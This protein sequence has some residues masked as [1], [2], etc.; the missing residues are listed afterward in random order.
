MSTDFLRDEGSFRDPSGRV[1]IQG[2][3]IL[4]AI[5]DKGMADFQRVL[6]SRV[7][8][9]D[10]IARDILAARIVSTDEL[11]LLRDS[12]AREGFPVANALQ[13]RRLPLISYPYEWSFEALRA[14]GLAHL[15]L[16]KNLLHAGFT[17]S[18]ASAFNI[19]FEG[20]S[21]VHIDTLSIIPYT[22]GDPWIA[23][24][25]FQRHFL[26]PLLLESLTG[27]SFT[28]W[29]RGSMDGLGSSDLLRMLPWR[30]L[31][32][33]AVLTHVVPSALMERRLARVEQLT[34]H[35]APPRLP[36][37]R[38]EAMLTHLEAILT[39]MAKPKGR[40]SVWEDY[41]SNNNYADT[42]TTQ[43]LAQVGRFAKART[44]ELLLDIGCNSGAYAQHALT[45][46]AKS[47]VGIENDRGA[48]DLAF[49]RAQKQKLPFCALH[50]DI[51]NPSPAQGWRGLERKA[52]D[53][54]CKPDA[55]LALA[56]LHHIVIRG[57]VPACE[58]IIHLASLAPRG[59]I[60]FVPKSDPQVARMLRHREDI[61]P[62]YTLDCL[63]SAL[64]TVARI[65][66]VT[67]ITQS[68]RCLIEYERS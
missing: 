52:F 24:S 46:G 17:L 60:E 15:R 67:Q 37:A 66:A 38:L 19:Q 16:Q 3:N 50:L 61:F 64:R 35:K 6:D 1:F 63:T 56:V 9:K 45:Q 4:R 59:L 55:L 7:L 36:K 34:L 44:P 30:A 21:P 31:L 32:S 18:D 54:R 26:N 12:V 14:A 2:N 28:T 65:I 53:A 20:A 39:G 29:W 25:Q 58:A 40:L 13:T 51:T 22:D 43:K 11:Q 48:L 41:T 57:N 5:S 49:L 23:Y 27:I 62:D 47:V 68:G 8:E 33:P 10:E 42:E